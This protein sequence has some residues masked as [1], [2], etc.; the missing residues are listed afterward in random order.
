MKQSTKDSVSEFFWCEQ[1]NV[2]P[3]KLNCS[4]ER[5][6]FVNYAGGIEVLLPVNLLKGID[7]S[8]QGA[9]ITFCVKRGEYKVINADPVMDLLVK[10]QFILRLKDVRRNLQ[11]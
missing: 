7:P 9:L 2:Y 3:S 4:Y 10:D 11:F 5:W 6:L 8:G 1:L